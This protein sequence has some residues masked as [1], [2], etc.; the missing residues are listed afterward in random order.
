MSTYTYFYGT[1]NLTAAFAFA[2]ARRCRDGAIAT[3]P[4]EFRLLRTGYTS[5]VTVVNAVKNGALYVPQQVGV[6]PSTQTVSGARF[7]GSR[8]VLTPLHLGNQTTSFP[9]ASSSSL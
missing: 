8:V 3:V 7:V 4:V 1:K 6:T 9:P 5:V 2:Q